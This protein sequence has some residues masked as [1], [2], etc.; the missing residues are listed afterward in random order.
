MIFFSFGKRTHSGVPGEPQCKYPFD[1][2]GKVLGHAFIPSDGRIHF[3]DEEYYTDWY[4]V[5]L[6]SMVSGSSN[7]NPHSLTNVQYNI[8]IRFRFQPPIFNDGDKFSL[9]S[10]VTVS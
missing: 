3:D 8:I 9:V 2:P 4:I 10:N 7:I 6:A 5:W 1:G